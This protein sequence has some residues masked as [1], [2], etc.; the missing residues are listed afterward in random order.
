MHSNKTLMRENYFEVLKLFTADY[1]AEAFGRD[2]EH[3]T[4][5]SQRTLSDNLLELE[6]QRILKS[7][8]LGNLK[9]FSLNLDN[10]EIKDTISITEHQ[11]KI[12]FLKKHRKLAYLFKD[13][14]RVVGIFGSYAKGIETKTSDLDVFIIGDKRTNDYGIESEKLNLEISIKYFSNS[15]WSKLLKEKNPLAVEIMNA[16]VLIFGIEQF[17][18]MAWRDYYGIN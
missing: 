5:I 9:L 17:I 3:K 13:D 15:V 18:S 7:R 16:H 1:K 4:G 11:R 8:T 6:E 12:E 10:T 14:N 2:M